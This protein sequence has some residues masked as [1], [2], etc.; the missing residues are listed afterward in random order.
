MSRAKPGRQLNK[1][2]VSGAKEEQ[3]EDI[4]KITSGLEEYIVISDSS[5]AASPSS[6]SSYDN[7]SGSL[8]S[9]SSS[10]EDSKSSYRPVLKAA[11]TTGAGES[12]KSNGVVEKERRAW[13]MDDFYM[14]YSSK[15]Y[16][17]S[18]LYLLHDGKWIKVYGT[19]CGDNLRVV[20]VP[21]A[22]AVETYEPEPTVENILLKELSPSM[23]TL[24]SFNQDEPL[25][26]HP[27]NDSA[28][29]VFPYDYINEVEPSPPIPYTC[30]FSID[31]YI[32]SSLSYISASSWVNAARLS[33][34]E[35]GLLNVYFSFSLL[36]V[37]PY[38]RIWSDFEIQPFKT[39]RVKNLEWD[40]DCKIKFGI[41]KEWSHFYC[42]INSAGR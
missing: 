31:T 7:R 29:Q 39:K 25:F 36:R 15:E 20:K 40:G 23:K 33:A 27:I 37:V 1:R 17:S 26:I 8:S 5:S 24:E 11:S 32:F 12:T 28:S 34:Y 18:Y 22:I 41:D 30:F 16:I 19:I 9:S 6:P 2:H 21:D 42:K 38:I 4:A 35:N 14:I 3:D 10:S 13:K